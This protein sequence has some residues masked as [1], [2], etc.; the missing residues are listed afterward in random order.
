LDDALMSA[1]AMFGNFS[2]TVGNRGAHPVSAQRW[3]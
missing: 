3:R 2:I 1:F